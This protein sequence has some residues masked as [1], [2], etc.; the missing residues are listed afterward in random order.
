MDI[1]LINPHHLGWSKTKL[2][3][4]SIDF[5]WDAVNESQKKENK[6]NAKR[7]LVGNISKS[8]YLVDKDDWFLNNVLKHH[9]NLHFK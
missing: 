5:I 9:A 3:K 2:N 1:T 6:N 4:K 8:S 7:G